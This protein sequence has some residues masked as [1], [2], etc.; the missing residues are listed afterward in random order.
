MSQVCETLKKICARCGRV[1]T[2]PK[3]RSVKDWFERSRFCSVVCKEPGMVALNC[4]SCGSQFEVK[5][6]RGKTA[7]FCSRICASNFR[8]EGKRSEHK[9][10]RQSAEYKKWRLSVFIR[11]G[12]KCS[13]CGDSNHKGKGKS[14][15]LQADHIKPFALHPELRFDIGNG[16]TLCYPCHKNTETFGRGAVFRSSALVAAV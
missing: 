10:I 1:Y 5:K 13:I 11:D 3:T 7:K 8:D 4:L 2:K 15:V 14:I 6:Y 9:K 16:R 12:F